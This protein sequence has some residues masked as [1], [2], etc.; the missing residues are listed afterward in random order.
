MSSS[1]DTRTGKSEQEILDEQLAR[2]TPSQQALY[3]SRRAS[4]FKGTIAVCVIY[5]TIA[6]FL[7]LLAL[8]SEKGRE[9]LARDL[10]PFTV[11]FI[12]GMIFV[13][14]VLTLQ[15]V[16]FKP[17]NYTGEDAA[18]MKCPDYWTLTETPRATLE[19]APSD[20]RYTMQ[21]MCI[22]DRATVLAPG[23]QAKTFATPDSKPVSK[24][25]KETIAAVAYGGQGN[26]A[27]R[28]RLNCNYLYPSL[29]AVKDRKEFPERPASM[30]CQYA[31]TCG[32][33]W[34]AACPQIP[35]DDR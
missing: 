12:A 15:V 33:S 29:M 25:L 21:Y 13:I 23:E 8:A 18:A 31:K 3:K 4:Y 10:L 34:T 6:V 20:A 5:G 2:L 27:T 19:A 11:T 32:V 28:G 16:N 14:V 30:R 7:F 17:P 24:K 35:T 22:N 26:D 1:T 9:L